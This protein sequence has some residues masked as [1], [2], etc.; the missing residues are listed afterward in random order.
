MSDRRSTLER[1]ADEILDVVAEL[2]DAT[3]EMLRQVSGV[4]GEETPTETL[5]ERIDQLDRRLEGLEQAYDSLALWL[6]RTA[7]GGKKGAGPPRRT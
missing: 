1:T 4:E 2:H 3:K 5:R 6:R 7:V